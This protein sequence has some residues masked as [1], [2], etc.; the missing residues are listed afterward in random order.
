MAERP[1]GLTHDE[2]RA[3]RPGSTQVLR[4]SDNRVIAG[5][6]GGVAQF[7]NANPTTVRWGFGVLLIF[8]GGIF[9]IPYL[10][11]WLL[12]PGPESA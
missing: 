1:D 4:R 12:L 3:R 11:L 9:L 7:I 5:V 2:R 10:L 8:S 6:A